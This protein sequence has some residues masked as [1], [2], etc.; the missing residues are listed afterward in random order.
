MAS[1][2]ER[3]FAACRAEGRA[4]LVTYVMGGDPDLAGSRAMALACAAGGADLLEIGMPFSD[5]I[6]DGPVIQLAAERALAGGTGESARTAASCRGRSAGRSR[7]A[8][9]TPVTE[10]K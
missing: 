2:I 8:P 1:R 9:V 3:T 4:A 10:T 6:A 5:P 7:R